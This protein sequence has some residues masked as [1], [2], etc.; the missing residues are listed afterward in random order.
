MKSSHLLLAAL[1]LVTS[2]AA[3]S[4]VLSQTFSGGLIREGDPAGQVFAGSFNRASPGATVQGLTV[5]VQF[6]GG[7]NGDL[8]AALL[9][10]DGTVTELFNQPGTS[11][12]GFGAGG[13][14]MNVTFSDTAGRAIQQ[15][16]SNFLLAG[17]YRPAGSLGSLNGISP[18]GRWELYFASLGTGGGDATLGGWSLNITAV[19]EP[20]LPALVT[21]AGVLV[22]DT[23]IR[24]WGWR[25]NVVKTP[26]PPRTPEAGGLQ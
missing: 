21:L 18:N 24:R 12:N 25:K 19:P 17:N 9:A 16:T 4:V 5:D 8:Y 23:L 3:A 7:Y 10:P 13:A 1:V 26:P 2:R 11:V 22:A 14:G 20:E 15:E 6:T